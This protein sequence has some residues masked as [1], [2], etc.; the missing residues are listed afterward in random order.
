MIGHKALSLAEVVRMSRQGLNLY[1]KIAHL[2]PIP[3]LVAKLGQLDPAFAV[4]RYPRLAILLRPDATVFLAKHPLTARVWWLNYYLIHELIHYRQYLNGARKN[5]EFSEKEAELQGQLYADRVVRTYT[6]EQIN[7]AGKN[8]SLD[9][10]IDQ[11][12]A[13]GLLP[14]RVDLKKPYKGIFSKVT[15]ED[16]IRAWRQGCVI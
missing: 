1:C 10:A 6:K 5:E 8:P 15:E 11:C 3:L 2:K 4:L 7:P 16:R 12:I 9:D 13:L 14:T